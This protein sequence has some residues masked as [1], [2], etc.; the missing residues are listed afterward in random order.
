MAERKLRCRSLAT[1][2]EAAPRDSESFHEC[3]ELVYNITGNETQEGDI[4]TL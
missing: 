4:I 3:R 1:G 2:V